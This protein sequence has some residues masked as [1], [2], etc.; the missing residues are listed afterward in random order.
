MTHGILATKTKT[1]AHSIISY[2]ETYFERT[3]GEAKHFIGLKIIRNRQEHKLYVHQ[4]S[5]IQTLLDR[6]RMTGCNPISTP[7]DPNSHLTLMDCPKKSNKEPMLCYGGDQL[8][9]TLVA[10]T[11][12]N[13]AAYPDTRR[14][15]SGTIFMFNSGPIAWNS[16]LQKSVAQ[17]T[18]WFSQSYHMIC[19]KIDQ[20]WSP[21]FVAFPCI[22]FLLKGSTPY[23]FL[24]FLYYYAYG[25]RGSVVFQSFWEQNFPLENHTKYIRCCSFVPLVENVD[26]A[27]P[28]V[29]FSLSLLLFLR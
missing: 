20:R 11:D 19:F 22:C 18:S 7:A 8:T 17:S 25:L 6:F 1:K 10:Y 16:H 21:H 27:L 3:S 29:P 24:L 4:R 28:L 13:F 12:S 5:F 2:L 9:N 15:T 26:V 23:L 14:S